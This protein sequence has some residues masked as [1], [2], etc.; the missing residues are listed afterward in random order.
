MDRTL[1]LTGFRPKFLEALMCRVPVLIRHL[2]HLDHLG[3]Q[4]NLLHWPIYHFPVPVLY[5]HHL[6]RQVYNVVST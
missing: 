2:D 3:R 6:N 4:A 5:L 1:A